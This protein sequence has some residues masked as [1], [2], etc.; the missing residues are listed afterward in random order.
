M[1]VSSAQIQQLY[2]MFYGRPADPVG[3]A[4][5]QS[6]AASSTA[7][8]MTDAS[9]LSAFRASFGSNA[10]Y[11]AT[12]TGLSDVAKVNLVYNNLFSH[13]ADP[14]GLLY[15]AG[16]L[17]AGTL[18]V[19]TI[20]EA[21]SSSA[22]TAAN[23]D[24][25]AFTSK[26]TASSAFTAALTTTAQIV[27]YTGTTAGAAAKAWITTINSA[28][29]LATAIA[30]TALAATVTSVTT[31]AV[32]T[33]AGSTFTLTTGTNTFT[34]TAGADTFDAGLSTSS[35]QTLNS[36]DSLDGGAGTDELYAIVTSSVTPAAL[37]NIENVYLT[38]T[39][40]ATVDFTNATGLSTVSNQSS[41]VALTMSGI[42]S[43]SGPTVTVRDTAIAGQVVTYSDVTG[44]ADSAT[45]VL[46]NITSG[47]TLTV[48]GVETLTLQAD[49]STANVLTSL[50]SAATTTLKV[51]G[52]AL[53][54]GT[55]GS[56]VVV[57][58]ASANTGLSGVGVTAVTGTTSA[59]TI[60]GGSANDSFTVVSTANDSISAGAGT[61]TIWY[62]T[63]TWT[64]SDTVDGGAG[65]DTLRSLA[66]QFAGISTP[67]TYLTTNIETLQITDAL[68]AST[69]TPVNI[70]AAA[71]RLNI[72]GNTSAAG[73]AITTGA[74]LSV[75]GATIAGPAGAFTIGL[76]TSL[77]T[78]T[79]GI[80]AAGTTLTITDTGTATTDSLTIVNSA[81]V[82]S[83]SMLNVFNAQILPISGYETVTINTG[84]S[85]GVQQ[86]IAAITLTGD[87]SANT[88][89]NFTGVNAVQLTGTATATTIDASGITA[90]GTGNAAG[91]A[92][93]FMTGA[94]VATTVT[95]SAGRDTIYG[96]A[97]SASSVS[98]GAG[99]DSITGGSANDTLLGGDAIDTITAGSGNDSI[100]AGAGDD[101]IV[102][103]GNLATGDVI[104]GGAGTDTLSVSAAIAAA[105]AAT[106]S[107]VEIISFSA[108]ASQDMTAFLN[109]GIT[110]LG[111]T[112]GTLTVTNAQT[113]LT[114]L[115]AGVSGAG[116]FTG[117][118]LTRLVD[119]SAD[120]LSLLFIDG[121]TAPTVGTASFANEE[122]LTIGE[123]GTDSTAAITVALGTVTATS[124][125]TLNISGSNNHTMTLSGETK[126]ATVAAS[127]ATGTLSI[128]GGNSAVNMT[129]TGPT[130]TAMTIVAGSGNDSITGGS[131]ADSLTGG[132]GNDTV[133]GGAGGDT[134]IGGLGIDSL[135]GGDGTDTI[136][137]AYTLSTDG[138]S[139]TA[140]G[141]VINLS[142][143]A[144]AA[145]T[146]AGYI[147]TG[148]VVW[149]INTDLSSVAAGTMVN[150]GPTAN[151]AT[152]SS[153]V[154]TLSGF[155]AIQGSTGGDYLVGNSSANTITGGSLGDVMVGGSGADT[156]A[157]AGTASSV[158]A[159][160]ETLAATILTTNTI[161]FGAGVDVI[162]DFT[163]GTDF[164]DFTVAGATT[165]P[166]S[167]LT[168][169]AQAA[170]VI[171]TSYFLLGTYVIGTGVFTVN[172]AATSAT[173]NVAVAVLEA[174]TVDTAT[175]ANH[176]D[177]VILM[178]IASIATA[179][180]V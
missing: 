35:L 34:G 9:I 86:T 1:A 29:T 12:F 52:G 46:N 44:S 107:N 118:S 146:I 135:V 128:L 104:D 149:G 6:Q 177:W 170:L 108:T 55:L 124:L 22:V 172:T 76:G 31:A 82:T 75:D 18:T 54:V 32:V 120:A 43:V 144:V 69:Y 36:G 19:A 111:A 158:A 78:N 148:G 163:S 11:T 2:V 91:T 3:L 38:A 80:L 119:G 95:G 153:R 176:T 96:H 23:V 61:D 8:G 101:S 83:G 155:E 141:V 168:G 140:T 63:G 14:S 137:A 97:S 53:N 102:M 106:I 47:A 154:D 10:E 131:S 125:T 129:V 156:F 122:T 28:A 134:I 152:T 5:W 58:D 70:S 100:D 117:A 151:V 136:S 126:L 88:T 171:G 59:T 139:T 49:G 147:N 110:T 81:M 39:T 77:A 40:A 99:R 169:A 165:A 4:Y 21:V 84:T 180:I 112:A 113:T 57:I 15:W 48:A 103:A 175:S 121:S 71:T 92:A 116:L 64:T 33:V 42:K 90:S 162:T 41:T 89:L 20:A 150:V 161:T 105:A 68:A 127:G 67:T 65:T 13:D 66:V 27:G 56:T 109:A 16:K 74:A 133:V 37:K 87:Q 79:L 179:D 30:S 50:T 166:T 45:V 60:T 7:S 132:T 94:P 62:S 178:G 138:G 123:S 114:S 17:T 157:L 25:T 85:S 72:T 167:L 143:S 93:F 115:I 159:T 173:T 26:V 24:G 164:L 98:G 174:T 73:A 142:T 145:A 160:A 130:T 51:T